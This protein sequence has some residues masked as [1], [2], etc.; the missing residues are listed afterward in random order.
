MKSLDEVLRNIE[1]YESCMGNRFSTR[2]LQFM[3]VEQ[4]DIIGFQLKDGVNSEEWPEPLPWTREEIL[5]QLE[6]DVR[7]G[8][9]KACNERGISSGL[10]YEVV[11]SWNKILEDGLELIDEYEMYG[12]PLFIATAKKYGWILNEE[13]EVKSE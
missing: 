13:S 12:K 11:Q 5:K 7:F 1:S 8:W 10:M 6:E 3:N 9:E 2:L 4:L